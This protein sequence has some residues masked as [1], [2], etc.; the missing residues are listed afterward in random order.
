LIE[1]KD[2]LFADF[3]EYKVGTRKRFSAGDSCKVE[4][5]IAGFDVFDFL[6]E[7]VRVPEVFVVDAAVAEQSKKVMLRVTRIVKRTGYCGRRPVECC[8]W[9]FPSRRFGPLTLHRTGKPCFNASPKE[10]FD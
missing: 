1:A 4:S 10:G 3:V 7:F 9:W 8:C 2:T 6:S 5:W